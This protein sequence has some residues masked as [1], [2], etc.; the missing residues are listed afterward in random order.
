MAYNPGEGALAISSPSRPCPKGYAG[1]NSPRRSRVSDDGRIV[2]AANRLHDRI[3][4][5]A[6]DAATAASRPRGTSGRGAA[7]RRPGDRAAGLHVRPA[8]PQRQHHPFAVARQTGDLKSPGS[9]LRSGIRP[10]SCSS[11]TSPPCPRGIPRRRQPDGG[12]GPVVTSGQR[13]PCAPAGRR[14]PSGRR[15]ASDAAGHHFRNAVR[16]A[17][18]VP[19]CGGRWEV[20]RRAPVQPLRPGGSR[21][22]EA[23]AGRMLSY[24]D[25][26]SMPSPPWWRRCGGWRPGPA[27]RSRPSSSSTSAVCALRPLDYPAGAPPAATPAGGPNP[28]RRAPTSRSP[29]RSSWGCCWARPTTALAGAPGAPTGDLG[30]AACAPGGRPAV[31]PARSRRRPGR[32]RRAERHRLRGWAVRRPGRPRAGRRR[33]PQQPDLAPPA[34]AL[35]YGGR[36]PRPPRH[37]VSPAGKG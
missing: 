23:V 16:A 12:A 31:P 1:T 32:R 14:S 26:N 37:S 27:Y 3:A 6:I 15:G 36:R 7:T 34:G 25:G 35:P 11:S 13:R 19:R 18:P 4:V 9:T 2:Y 17:G 10:T 20:R 24:L 29:A 33:R 8:L 30:A 22:E 5:F 21:P 28:I